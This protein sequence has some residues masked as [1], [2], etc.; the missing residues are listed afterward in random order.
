MSVGLKQ[1]SVVT[2]E[3]QCCGL[4][5]INSGKQFIS[6]STFGQQEIRNS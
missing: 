4:H 1:K 6:R 3:L 5:F 2:S